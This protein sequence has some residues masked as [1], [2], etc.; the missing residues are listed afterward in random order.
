[1]RKVVYTSALFLFLLLVCA[2]AG[3]LKKVDQ[4][5]DWTT[6]I[7]RIVYPNGGEEIPLGLENIITWD[8]VLSTDTVTLE[9]STNYGKT[10]SLIT[11]KATG[12]KYNWNK[13]PITNSTKCLVKVIYGEVPEPPNEEWSKKYG[14]SKGEIICSIRQTNDSGYIMAGTTASSDG[15]VSGYRDHA[16]F[17][18]VKLD[19]NGNIQWQKTYGGSKD[20]YATSLQIAS[21]GGY[22]IAGYSYS[23][24]WDIHYHHGDNYSSDF[25]VIKV[26][27]NGKLLW[28]SSYG[29]KQNEYAYSIENTLDGGYIVAGESYSDNGD[30]KNH[31][32]KTDSSDC[33]V[34]K[35][36]SNGYY[37]WSQSYGGS[38]DDVAYSIKQTTDKGYIVAGYTMSN[39]LDVSGNHGYSNII[40]PQDC[41]IFKID[42]IGKIEWQKCFGGKSG[43]IATSILQSD[44]G[45]YIFVGETFSRDGDVSG[46]HD[47]D[48]L[49]VVKLDG[50]GNLEWQKCLGGHGAE[51]AHQIIKT[52][53]NAYVVVGETESSDGD[54]VREYDNQNCWL[55]K[56]DLAG[57]LQ[58]QST[59]DY[60]GGGSGKSV[61][62]TY[63]GGFIIAGANFLDNYLPAYDG[64]ATKVSPGGSSFY[65]QDVS[66]SIWT[67]VRPDVLSIDLEM[68]QCNVGSE[69]D[70][71]ISE[72]IT[73]QGKYPFT[74]DSIY[75]SGHDSLAFNYIGT[76]HQ[77]L[78]TGE[79]IN[80]QL[81]FKPEHSGIN[82]SNLIIL[83]GSDI[84][85][86]FIEGE[87][88]KII[89]VKPM[90]STLNNH[91]MIIGVA[92]N[93]ADN[94]INIDLSLKEI[95]RTELSIYNLLGEQVML[96]VDEDVNITGHRLIT[97]N[98]SGLTTGQY[99]IVLK[100]PTILLKEKLA[101]V[102]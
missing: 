76:L 100:T 82:Y 91:S 57:N 59:Y 42:S 17:W 37:Q 95:G 2:R 86:Q 70:S 77:K 66:D 88:I 67:I 48:D 9:Y 25:W 12:L 56:L 36:D 49:W 33:W 44:D 7:P 4:L 29:G 52:A 69:K 13:M 5:L 18:V 50:I 55:I 35:L 27:Q 75:F 19:K 26:D 39:D 11:N 84:T 63:D 64:W 96:L 101:V 10:W 78:E 30:V 23:N 6:N 60:L 85:T 87:G 40:F 102:R 73:N 61:Q 47:F 51:I 15:D 79:S 3:D 92:P 58:W 62:Q 8:G 45:G 83:T 94:I 14:G 74:I 38:K 32:G 81:I 89:S 54:V 24:D 21:D 68:G 93:P 72:F 1:M 43:E 71:V 53:D 80:A 31:H 34:V 41:W 28:E 99:I 22:V 46:N 97:G 16:D 65:R 20:D 98:L 90:N